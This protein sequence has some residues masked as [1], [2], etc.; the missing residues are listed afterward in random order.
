MGGHLVPGCSPGWIGN[1]GTWQLLSNPCGAIV[2]H[3]PCLAK[4]MPR[5]RAPWTI[6]HTKEHGGELP[7]G[8]TGT[9]STRADTHPRRSC[10]L[11]VSVSIFLSVAGP[12]RIPG[13]QGS[14]SDAISAGCLNPSHSSHVPGQ[15]LP[16]GLG[17][18]LGCPPQGLET[19]GSPSQG[20]KTCARSRAAS[21]SGLTLGFGF[22]LANLAWIMDNL[23]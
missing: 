16:P 15:G 17:L 14:D 13:L 5:S 8:L 18:H 11:S 7:A 2:S 19:S 22:V 1:T 23:N 21:G 12:A 3:Q 4:Y 10:S 6:V 20:W 9:P